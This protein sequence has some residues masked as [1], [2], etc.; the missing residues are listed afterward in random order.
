[1]TLLTRDGTLDLGDNKPQ[2]NAQTPL[3]LGTLL[4]V[5]LKRLVYIFC[6]H[7]RRMEFKKNAQ[8]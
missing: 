7:K 2:T 4:L 6:T 8:K 5:V 3:F 1:M